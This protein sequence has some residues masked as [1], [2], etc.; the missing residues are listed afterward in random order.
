MFGRRAVLGL[1]AARGPVPRRASTDRL[2]VLSVVAIRAVLRRP[3]GRASGRRV[4]PRR[5][6]FRFRRADRAAFATNRQTRRGSTR[7]STKCLAG[8]S[9]CAERRPGRTRPERTSRRRAGPTCRTASSD[10]HHP[11]DRSTG[12]PLWGCRPES[13]PVR[14]GSAR[15]ASVVDAPRTEPHRA[16]CRDGPVPVQA[17]LEV[18]LLTR[19]QRAAA[20]VVVVD[21]GPAVA[22]D[23]DAGLVRV[24]R[25]A[26]QDTQLGP[27][28]DGRT[29][30][31]AGEGP[32]ARGVALAAVQDELAV[33]SREGR[34]APAPGC[35]SPTGR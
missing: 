6:V 28:A 5:A 12:A 33:R 35:R 11:R 18:A 21:D 25:E 23:A 32:R 24:G 10:V 9:A 16:R 22:P 31:G 15:S 34:A 1:F 17:D 2:C 27:L 13:G 4:G 14:S 30:E 7:R 26:H 8:S 19:V 29:P 3:L 20:R